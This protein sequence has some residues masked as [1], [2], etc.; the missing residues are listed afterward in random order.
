MAKFGRMMTADD[1][2]FIKVVNDVELKDQGKFIK[3]IPEYLYF[4]S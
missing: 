2:D 3:I 1:C 4:I